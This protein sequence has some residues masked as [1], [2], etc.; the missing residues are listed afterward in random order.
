[1]S[2]RSNQE[3]ALPEL[4]NEDL[5]DSLKKEIAPMALQARQRSYLDAATSENT[6]RSYRSA[7]CA[8]LSAGAGT[9]PRTGTP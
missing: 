5:P 9:C 8:T 4:R 7:P 2:D 3:G 6:R 1:M